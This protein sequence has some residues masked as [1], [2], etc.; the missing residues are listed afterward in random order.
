MTWRDR[1]LRTLRG[2][3][4][5]PRAVG[6]PTRF[7]VSGECPGGAR[8]RTPLRDASLDDVVMELDAGYHAVVPDFRDLRSP[9]DEQDRAL[10]IYNLW[11]VPYRTTLEDVERRVTTEGDSTLVEYRT[12]VGTVRTRMVYTEDMRRAGATI[13]HV[14]EPVVKRPEDLRVAAHL[15]D[16]ARVE[17]NAEGY[18]RFA[19]QVGDRG[20]AV[21]FVSLSASGM[22]LLQRELMPADQFFF[23]LHDHGAEMR[24]AARSVQGYL[25]RAFDVCLRSDADMLLCGANYDAMMTYPPFFREHFAPALRRYADALH[26][27]GRFLLTHTDGENQG[28]MEHYLWA[29]IDVADSICPTPMTRMTLRQAQEAFGRR[30]TIWGGVPSVALLAQSMSERDF[31]A[32]LDETLSNL[33]F[34]DHLIVSV[35]DTMPPAAEWSR[36]EKIGKALR[37]LGPVEPSGK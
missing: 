5:R 26:A 31:D 36:I 7:M 2:E 14:A 20:V 18:G 3:G 33:A 12:P 17:P 23:E 10:G 28:L 29:G 6:S 35:A 30:V 37:Q 15:Y 21:G 9:E 13:T 4:L 1:I 24:E 22:H 16:H 25:D 32:L 34:K 11:S 19:A 8:C 27:K